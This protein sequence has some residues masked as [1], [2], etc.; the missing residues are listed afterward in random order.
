MVNIYDCATLNIASSPYFV[1]FRI[2][3]GCQ[4]GA[5]RQSPINL[6]QQRQCQ[7][8]NELREIW[9]SF[10]VF[11]GTSPTTQ[12]VL[13]ISLMHDLYIS[14]ERGINILFNDSR[15]SGN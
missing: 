15:Y 1:L 11:L 8:M 7:Q 12:D 10:L 5:N 2:R 13:L 9:F 4:L 14:L 6:K 3:R